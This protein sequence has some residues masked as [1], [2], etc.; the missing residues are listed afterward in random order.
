[1]FYVLL[2]TCS[3]TLVGFNMLQSF[4]REFRTSSPP[5]PQFSA[6]L[7]Q[8]FQLHWTNDFEGHHGTGSETVHQDTWAMDGHGTSDPKDPASSHHVDFFPPSPPQKKTTFLSSLF[9]HQ[10]KKAY[11]G[12]SETTTDWG[13]PGAHLASHLD[14]HWRPGN[15]QRL[16]RVAA[17]AG[18][19]QTSTA[20][21]AAPGSWLSVVVATICR[22]KYQ[23]YPHWYPLVN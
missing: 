3:K 7:H 4:N 15:R 2:Q 21:T 14:L 5:V 9:S 19:R 17:G 23:S 16:R 12:D 1:M 22:L 6:V 11:F 18:R 20:Q 13:E 10:K 8:E